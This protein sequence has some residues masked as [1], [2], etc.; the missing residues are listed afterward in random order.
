MDV[1]RLAEQRLA[2][3][4]PAEALACVEADVRLKPADVKLR[5]FLFQ[6]LVILGQWQR[7][8][9]Q[10]DVIGELDAGALPM[11]HAYREA[12]RGEMLRARVFAGEAAPLVIGEPERWLAL[13]IEA[14]RVAAG[15]EPAAD[16]RLREEAFEQAPATGGL[17]ER[18]AVRL[19]C[20]RRPA[21]GAGARSLP[22]RRLLLDPRPPPAAGRDRAAVGSQGHGLDTGDPGMEQRRQDRGAHPDALS[23]LG[24]R[25][26]RHDPVGAE[27]RVARG[28][29]GDR[30]RRRPAGARHRRRRS[31][32][33]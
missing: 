18:R 12:I 33:S 15:A 13:L 28:R 2:A 11:V 27:D 5:I 21:A 17:A 31:T 19:A 8:L 32:R 22:Q 14:V 26:R 7:A 10:L 3:G 16:P 23:W 4:D 24:G 30:S 29:P 20:R 25:S 9:S 6:L 1:A